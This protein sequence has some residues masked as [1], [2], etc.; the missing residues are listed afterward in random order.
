MHL[1]VCCS[2]ACK[3]PTC[4]ATDEWIKKMWYIYTMEYYSSIKKNEIM[5]FAATWMD[6][7]I[8]ILSEVSQSKANIMWDYLYVGSNKNDTKEHIYKTETN[9]QISNQSYGYHRGN[10]CREGGI[11][12]VGGIRRVGITYTHYCIKLMTNQ[13]LLYSIGIYSIV[14][15]NLYGKEEWIYLHVWLIHS[16]IHLKLIQ[17]CRSTILQ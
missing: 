12:R 2:Q 4:P 8:I 5:L 10:C 14:C 3:Q 13:N 15:N 17:H 1:N 11:G 16:A 7:G 6:L 9:S